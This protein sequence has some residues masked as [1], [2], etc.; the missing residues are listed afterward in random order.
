MSLSSS[1]IRVK[2]KA[3]SAYKHK[4]ITT[5]RNY[6]IPKYPNSPNVLDY[7]YSIYPKDDEIPYN[8]EKTNIKDDEYHCSI[9]S[10]HGDLRSP[11]TN[12]WPHITFK[13]NDPVNAKRN[14]DGTLGTHVS[15]HY[16][17]NPNRR[18]VSD[19]KVI[20]DLSFW[21]ELGVD[22]KFAYED[23]EEKFFNSETITHGAD[24]LQETLRT[25]Y[26]KCK[27]NIPN[28]YNPNFGT[29]NEIEFI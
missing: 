2:K 27:N 18:T 14:K 24:I 23:N 12:D 10:N 19:H 13:K 16:G 26:K 11:V 15:Y 29:G 20:Q 21:P 6:Y 8:K 25:N 9:V 5:T 4:P 28:G 17:V 3:K 1:R 22:P 7:N